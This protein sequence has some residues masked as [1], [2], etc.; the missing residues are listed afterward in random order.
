MRKNLYKGLEKQQW[1]QHQE[2][3]V[4]KK[5]KKKSNT[6]QEIF[7][8]LSLLTFS[9]LWMP[10]SIEKYPD[11][12]IIAGLDI[13]LF[14]FLSSLTGCMMFLVS[15]ICGL[16]GYQKAAPIFL[17]LAIIIGFIGQSVFNHQ[18]CSTFFNIN[19]ELC[20]IA[21]FLSFFIYLLTCYYLISL[22]LSR[23]NF[24]IG[25]GD[26]KS[27]K[28]WFGSRIRVK[29]LLIVNIAMLIII[30]I[31]IEIYKYSFNPSD[32][33]IFWVGFCLFLGIISG[34]MTLILMKFQSCIP[35]V[36]NRWFLLVLMIITF[37][38]FIIGLITVWK[39]RFSSF[40][41]IAQIGNVFIWCVVNCWMF[42]EFMTNDVNTI[43]KESKIMMRDENNGRY[44]NVA[45][46]EIDTSETEQ[47][48]TE[49]TNDDDILL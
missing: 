34:S 15:I 46:T 16:E 4:K 20:F 40:D 1:N 22:I 38:A 26:L 42:I 25:V 28:N 19:Y 3:V 39:Y 35:Y 44:S 48:D 21:E 37:I 36:A 17:L 29:I 8:C 41:G 7:V 6:R 23:T 13:L 30:I 11:K 45:Q 49:N 9:S 14:S 33:D 32:L 27:L 12:E 18:Y 2:L 24:K 5:S 31:D 10:I 43:I 47:Y